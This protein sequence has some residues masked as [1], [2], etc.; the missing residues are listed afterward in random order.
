MRALPSV[1][2][3]P[4]RGAFYPHLTLSAPG[5]RIGRRP[6]RV[7][8]RRCSAPEGPMHG[9]AIYAAVIAGSVEFDCLYHEVPETRD[10]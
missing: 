6:T 4:P 5:L 8:F 10:D 9:Q 3:A 2:P 7:V 1:P